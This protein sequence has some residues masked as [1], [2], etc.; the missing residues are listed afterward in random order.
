MVFIEGF[1]EYDNKF[2]ENLIESYFESIGKSVNVNINDDDVLE[3]RIVWNPRCDRFVNIG[4]YN[5]TDQVWVCVKNGRKYLHLYYRTPFHYSS[6]RAR[7][8]YLY[9]RFPL[10]VISDQ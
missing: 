7:V 9:F 1:G 5:I 10:T 2:L 4:G 3:A 6:R 8:Y